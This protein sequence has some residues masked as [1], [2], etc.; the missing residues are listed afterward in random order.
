MPWHD[1]MLVT[2]VHLAEADF[3]SL[4]LELMYVLFMYILPIV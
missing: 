3:G 2:K 4:S 1:H